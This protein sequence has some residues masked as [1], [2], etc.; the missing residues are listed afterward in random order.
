MVLT[1]KK[2]TLTGR[3][4]SSV[5]TKGKAPANVI[6]DQR[7]II[8]RHIIG[9][10]IPNIFSITRNNEGLQNPT[11]TLS[12]KSSKKVDPYEIPMESNLV[13]RPEPW[14]IYKNLEEGRRII[15]LAPG[16]ADKIPIPF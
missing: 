5:K 12:E 14:I 10:T 2:Q 7:F 8:K 9:K 3:L 15:S 6:Q 16:Y 11:I 1:K 13:S 4:Q